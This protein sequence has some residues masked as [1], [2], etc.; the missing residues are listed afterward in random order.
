MVLEF[1]IARSADN[2]I[3]KEEFSFV[4]EKSDAK[5]IAGM[6]CF[7]SM[8]SEQI[9]WLVLSFED[10]VANPYIR[11]ALSLANPKLGLLLEDTLKTAQKVAEHL[12]AK[13]FECASQQEIR[14]DNVADLAD[15]SSNFYLDIIARWD[16][17]LI[18]MNARNA[19]PMELPAQGVDYVDDYF[20]FYVHP[21]VANSLLDLE[22]QLGFSMK[23][24]DSNTAAV[25]DSGTM[26]P[27]SKLCVE[28]DGRLRIQPFYWKDNFSNAAGETLQIAELVAAASLTELYFFQSPVTDQFRVRLMN[29]AAGL[30][31]AF[32]DFLASSPW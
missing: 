7:Y 24:K 26:R 23:H 25:F 19:A 11:L 13:L 20:C 32:R 21:S 8:Y 28:P 18:E 6:N 9:A 30:G 2:K 10:K 4:V 5:P 1:Q 31:F 22:K 27:M 14:A 12:N 17:C 29:A 3:T 16:T 15:S